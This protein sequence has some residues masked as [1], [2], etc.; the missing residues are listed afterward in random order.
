ME[1]CF[2]VIVASCYLSLNQLID[3]AMNIDYSGGG[4]MK[5]DADL[6]ST[7]CTS[8]YDLATCN[9]I[10][11]WGSLISTVI[12]QLSLFSAHMC[13][14]KQFPNITVVHVYLINTLPQINVHTLQYA[15]VRRL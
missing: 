13:C 2:R 5:I 4:E 7:G 12:S 6:V 9:C 15:E 10:L 1:P 3:V 8:Y 11:L 14:F